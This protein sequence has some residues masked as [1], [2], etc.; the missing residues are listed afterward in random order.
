M[1]VCNW[2]RFPVTE[3]V[4][5]H[6]DKAMTASEKVSALPSLIA[7]GMGRS[8]GDASLG[9]HILSTL[10]F[11]RFL[12]FNEE[13]GVLR[14]ES[15]VTLDEIIQV[16]LPR[17]WFLPVTPGTRFVTVGGAV[18]SD[19][20]GKNHH[21]TG[22]FSNHLLSMEILLSSG[23]ILTC[24]PRHRS[25]LFHATC[26]GMGLTGII[27]SAEFRLI[28]VQSA[29]IRRNVSRGRNL[30]EIMRLFEEHKKAVYS[31][32][33][34][35]CLSSGK[36]LGRSVL[37]TGHHATA[38]DLKGTAD[39]DEPFPSQEKMSF[40]VPL[41]LPSVILNRFSVRAFN[42][43]YFNGN[44]PGSEGIIHHAPFFFPLDRIRHWNRIYGRRGFFQYQFVLPREES[45]D[46]LREI[47][48]MSSASGSASFLAVLK[49]FGRQDSLMSFPMEG[50]TLAMDFPC[51]DANL[52]LAEK[53][54][55][56]VLR[57]KGRIYL[58]KD[59]RMP[60]E[61]FEESYPNRK[62]FGEILEKYDPEHKFSSLQSK[63]LGITP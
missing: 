58:T 54:D 17:G 28:P 63:R 4:V 55:Q 60:R 38:E 37:F 41:T 20:H 39:E 13:R 53:L 3:S 43:L 10:R 48:E 32:A 25:D 24:S 14:C 26:G 5:H 56:A 35:D 51:T 8:Y 36:N 23:E 21:L 45:F 27:L 6:F 19:I 34:I 57:R 44:R 9:S 61:V 30:D 18:A 22:S 15:G 11:N 31:V 40:N 59:A 2:G 46:G 29:F 62:K 33:W 1:K 7:R 16:F 47:L 42:T 12:S 50:Y 52:K 49:L